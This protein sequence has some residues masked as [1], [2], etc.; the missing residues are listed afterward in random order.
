MYCVS[1]TRKKDQVKIN[2]QQIG[3]IEYDFRNLPKCFTTGLISLIFVSVES[4][5][6]IV[7]ASLWFSSLTPCGNLRTFLSLRFYVK[8]ILE[9]L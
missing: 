7:S 8:S 5:K 3:V 6:Q 1:L 2:Q 9:K 4:F